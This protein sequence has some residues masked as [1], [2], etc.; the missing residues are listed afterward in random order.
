MPKKYEAIRD[1]AVA[2]GMNYDKAQTLAARIYNAERKKGEAP[3]TG[4]HK[5]K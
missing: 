1:K 5:K 4:S 2:R 3:V